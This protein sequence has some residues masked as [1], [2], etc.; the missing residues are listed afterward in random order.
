MGAFDTTRPL[1]ASAAVGLARRCL[2]E[3]TQ[4]ALQ[5]KTMGTEIFNHQVHGRTCVRSIRNLV[6]WKAPETTND[7]Q[8][9]LTTRY[10]MTVARP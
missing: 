5:R 7:P 4:Y 1:V 6:P 2:H 9:V 3:A 10:P 8:S